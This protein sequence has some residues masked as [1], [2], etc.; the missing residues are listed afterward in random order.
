MNKKHTLIPNDFANYSKEGKI[1][2]AYICGDSAGPAWHEIYVPCKYL[3]ETGEVYAQM[4]QG[5]FNTEQLTEYDVIVF[6]RQN[7][8][9]A[10]AIVKELKRIGKKTVFH[11]TDNFWEIPPNNPAKPHYTPEVLR[12][13]EAIISE[14]DMVTC[15]TPYLKSLALQFNPV[16]RRP[17]E[18]V[19]TDLFDS[20]RLP[21]RR[22]DDDSIRIGWVLTPHH[23][24]DV[25]LVVNSLGQIARKYKNT[26]FVF[27][28]HFNQTLGQTIPANQ[29]EA[30]AGVHVWDYFRAAA[31]LDL[32]IGIA[33]VIAHPFNRGKSR[34]KWFEYSA[35]HTATVCSD[36][37]T[38]SIGVEH[39]VNAYKVKK[40]R[41]I[42]WTKGLEY[43]IENPDK[44]KNMAYNAWKH[45][46]DYHHPKKYIH[47]WVN[48]YR[49]L[50]EQ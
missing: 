48:M 21:P 25:Y 12:R 22:E 36:Y 9:E 26:K 40:N 1:K 19:E 32:D 30:Y 39:M 42:N 49:R 31:T 43:L 38:Y 29:C 2:I 10:L 7:S 5:S 44:R 34:R 41:A 14:C 46:H 37:Y 11:F 6:Q 23:E 24:D 33:P 45:V 20:W 15:T 8:P 35:C 16:V 28:G 13:M 18:L 50:L 4:M 47:K 3:N 17:W 27:F